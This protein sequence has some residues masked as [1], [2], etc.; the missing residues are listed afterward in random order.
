MF[1]FFQDD[2][3]IENAKVAIEKNEAILVDVRE[4]DEVEAGHLQ[5]AFWYPLSQI[6]LNPQSA[7]QKLK[8]KFPNKKFLFYCRSGNRSGM[9]TSMMTDQGLESEN[10][11]GF[12]SLASEF[13]T[14]DG[15]PKNQ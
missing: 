15:E 2:K 12:G 4:Q 7:A 9:V 8:E 1:G 10:L 11:G 13:E 3:K 6:Q 5:D 14:T